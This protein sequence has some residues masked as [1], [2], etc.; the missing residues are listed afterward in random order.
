M[1]NIPALTGKQIIDALDKIGF[2]EIRIRGCHHYMRHPN[3]RSTVVPSH[4]GET[5]GRGLL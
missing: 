2:R 1:S 4:A 5:T 3:G